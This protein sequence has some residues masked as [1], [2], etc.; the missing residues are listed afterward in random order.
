MAKLQIR[1]GTF[2]TN[3]SST[4][5]IHVGKLPADRAKWQLPSVRPNERGEIILE[6]DEF[7]WEVQHYSDANSRLNY[8]VAGAT[9]NPKYR[10]MIKKVLS[11][12]LGVPQTSIAFASDTG[13]IDHQ[14]MDD[15]RDDIFSDEASL[16]AFLFSPY[17]EFETDNDNH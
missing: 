14:S 3:S 5:S 10:K 11:D 6:G 4:H 17:S 9:E 12:A 8:A 2:E 15:V 1:R 16:R 7:G 13:Y